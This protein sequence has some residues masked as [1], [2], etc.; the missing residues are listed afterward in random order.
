M[1]IYIGDFPRDTKGKIWQ[2]Q[3]DLQSMDNSFLMNMSSK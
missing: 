2:S 1:Y 3:T